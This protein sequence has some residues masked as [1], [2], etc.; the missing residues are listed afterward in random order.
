[1]VK[2]LARAG[3][4]DSG[5]SGPA[6]GR[7]GV[8]FLHSEAAPSAQRL[9]LGLLLRGLR[10]RADL[11]QKDVARR[12]KWSES[13]ISRIETGTFN[14][15]AVDLEQLAALYAASCEESERLRESAAH[16]NE[17]AWWQP[18]KGVSHPY[19]EAMVSCEDLA[20]RVRSYEPQI[21]NG[22]LQAPAYARELI[23]RGRGDQDLHEQLWQFRA[24]RQRRFTQDAGKSFFGVVD[25]ASLLRPV[26]TAAIMLEQFEHLLRLMDHGRFH[27]RLAEQSNPR[28]HTEIG[29]TTIFD[30]D[31]PMMPSVAYAELFDGSVA[32]QDTDMVDR[33]MQKFD[34]LQV[35][36]LNPA[37]T[38]RRLHDLLRTY[39]RS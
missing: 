3:G 29:P 32:Y 19:L 39:P 36:S 1:M 18:W 27:L 4:D 38:R 24:E 7:S 14:P 11:M 23:S 2:D 30:F 22:L 34:A 8:R 28:V 20:V 13:K 17:P 12:L 25:E 5:A 35:A 26:G 15:K 33:R 37:A 21:L 31:E 9:R 16:A 10:R 6:G